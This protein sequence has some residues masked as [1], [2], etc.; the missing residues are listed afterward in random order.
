MKQIVTLIKKLNFKK[1]NSTLNYSDQ[2]I[3]SIMVTTFIKKKFNLLFIMFLTIV[4][5]TVLGWIICYFISV[6]LTIDFFLHSFIYIIIMLYSHLIFDIL[7]VR[8]EYF[9]KLT[10]YVVNNYTIENYKRWKRNIFLVM[11]LMTIIFCSFIEINSFILIYYTFQYVLIYCIVDI[12]ENKKLQYFLKQLKNK[13]KETKFNNL[14]IFKNYYDI[15]E[16]LQ[17]DKSPSVTNK[18]IDEEYEEIN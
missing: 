12:I 13:P 6:N 8:K 9:Y 2:I 3:R 18:I 14:T 5:R 15:S 4:L 7:Y 17:N 1:I 11:S 10:K 16:S